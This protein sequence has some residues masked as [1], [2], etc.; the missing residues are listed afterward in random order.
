MIARADLAASSSAG[1][2]TAA[3]SFTVNA[4]TIAAFASGAGD[5]NECCV[6][7]ARAGGLIGHPCLVFS[8]QWNGG[9]RCR[10]DL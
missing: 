6:D 10:A 2:C 5:F 8:F 7:D 9:L 1:R 4:R 3:K